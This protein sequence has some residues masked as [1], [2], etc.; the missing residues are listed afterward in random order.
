MRCIF[1]FFFVITF[2]GSVP[3]FDRVLTGKGGGER[4]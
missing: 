1:Y 4:V 3:L 2:G